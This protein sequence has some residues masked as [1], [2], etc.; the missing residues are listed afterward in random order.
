MVF[1]G[2]EHSLIQLNEISLWSGKV[3]D[4]DNPEFKEKFLQIRKLLSEGNYI[5][6]EK[7]AARSLICREG[8]GSNRGDGADQPCGAYQPLGDLKLFFSGMG[9]WMP[10]DYHRELD[11]DEAI[12]KTR[13]KVRYAESGGVGNVEVKH[14]VFASHPAQVLVIRLEVATP[15][16]LNF[17]AGLDREFS[18]SIKV[19]DDNRMILRGRAHHK[20]GGMRFE[21]QL[22]IVPDDGRVSKINNR[23]FIEDSTGV[24]LLVAGN[25]SWHGQNPRKLTSEQIESAAGQSYSRLLQEHIADYQRLFNRVQ[26]KVSTTESDEVPTDVRLVNVNKGNPDLHLEEV[27]FQ[28][29]RYLLNSSSRNKLGLPANLQGLWNNKYYPAWSCDYHTNINLQM[30]YWLSESTNLAECAEPLFDF[31]ASLCKPGRKS[32]RVHYGARGWIV[33]WATNV[34]GYTSP[35]ED[36]GWGLFPAAAAWLCRHL[37]EHYEYGGEQEFLKSIYPILKEAALFYLDY[38]VEEP[39][40]SCLVSGPSTSPENQFKTSKGQKASISMGPTMEMEIAWD[41]FTNCIKACDQLDLDHA[42]KQQLIQARQRLAPLQIGTDGRLQEWIEEFEE[43]DPGHRHISHAF[44]L[45]PGEQITRETPAYLEAIRKSIEYRLSHGGGQTG[46]SG[47]WLVALWARLGEGDKAYEMLQILL[48]SNVLKNLFSKAH[49]IPQLDA[50]F[51]LT[52][53]ISEMLLQS[54]AG[55]IRLL[56]ALPKAWKDG[57][58]RG[59][60]ARGGFEIDLEWKESLLI[61]ATI[62]SRLGKPCRVSTHSP[63]LVKNQGKLI[64]STESLGFLFQTKKLET[65]E[66]V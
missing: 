15:G 19:M 54:H 31:I 56:P 63:H 18:D 28:Y 12:I 50:T 55:C 13:Y 27:C 47:A 25:T 30:N 8:A 64:G 39:S 29:G 35:G 5:E 42:F 36:P 53:G 65:Y 32:A 57:S 6:S 10:T 17:T 66:I 9:S 59:L 52:A 41:L 26:F 2:T 7:I 21:C 3:Q 23:L 11:L 61:K 58:V 40:R 44:A 33:N 20:Q 16:K 24:T 49:E 14:A 38:L 46:W 34:W 60:R 62:V 4:A 43:V 22:L 1:G 37:W 48:K 45:Y 51:G